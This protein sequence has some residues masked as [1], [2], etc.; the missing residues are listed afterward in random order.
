M[1]RFKNI[2][3]ILLVCLIGGLSGY[4]GGIVS[5]N[6]ASFEFSDSRNIDSFI[7][8][9]RKPIDLHDDIASLSREIV[10]SI[11]AISALS[12]SKV[13]SSKLKGLL[14]DSSIISYGVFVTGDGWIVIAKPN[15]P[16]SQLR[17]TFDDGSS[18]PIQS[19][20]DDDV[21][22]VSFIK[23]NRTSQRAARFTDND[24]VM[25]E[26]RAFAATI[27]GVIKEV[28]VGRLVYPPS[29]T[30]NDEVRTTRL[31]E[32][33]RSISSL[34]NQ[35]IPLFDDSG[36]F[37]GVTEANGMIDGSY[38]HD[39]LRILLVSSALKRSRI[40]ISY[41]DLAHSVYQEG[42]PRY[43]Q[44]A[45]IHIANQRTLK[46]E[47]GGIVLSEGDRVTHVN[48]DQVNGNA[49]LSELIHEYA[50]GTVVVLTIVALDDAEK[51]VRVRL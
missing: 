35:S 49:S 41:L 34:F 46:T 29:E 36:S 25:G 42:E 33:R 3:N 24:S 50:D 44:G 22:P 9:P 7:E 48:G 20:I 32:K 30:L 39:A 6:S 10:P 21:L 26:R 11:V 47:Q 13:E 45:L 15:E 12:S 5:H 43:R 37:V 51:M 18:L 28:V 23:V 14:T 16:T 38:I 2:L 31:L 8:Q 19:R 17:V 4:I 27:K 1:E 40:D